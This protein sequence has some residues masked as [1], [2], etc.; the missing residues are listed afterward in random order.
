MSTAAIEPL[1]LKPC[2]VKCVQGG[3]QYDND[4]V[5]KQN[6]GKWIVVLFFC[7]FAFEVRWGASING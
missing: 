3:S 7:V 4:I 1:V 6:N 5:V 2:G